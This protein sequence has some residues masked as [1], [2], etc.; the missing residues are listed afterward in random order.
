VSTFDVV[1]N[2][3]ADHD[4]G[5][6]GNWWDRTNV[7]FPN[8][9]R[10][11]QYASALSAES[12]RGILLWQVPVGN[13]YFDTENN[14]PGHTQDN[15]AAYILG[16]IAD[17]ANAGV[18]G[19]LFG[20]GT[21]GTAVQDSRHDGVTNPAPISTYECNRCNTHTSIYADD[22]GGYLRI[23]VGSYYISGGYPLGRG[24]PPTPTATPTGSPTSSPTSSPTACT[25]KI[26]FGSDGFAPQPR[27]RSA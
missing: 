20:P 8:F 27:R 23:T 13:Q 18:I 7:T 26:T 9:N 1:S 17:F 25:P 21:S 15:K 2:D 4:S 19:V 16:H 6:S 5:Q 3:I 24:T 11:L 10:Y 14:S 12:G 22:D